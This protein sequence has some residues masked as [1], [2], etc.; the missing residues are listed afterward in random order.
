MATINHYQKTAWE[1]VIEG[2]L[3]KNPAAVAL[4]R[5]GGRKGGKARAAKMTPEERSKAA[6]K[7]ARARWK[8][9]RSR[10]VQ[11]ESDKRGGR[12]FLGTGAL[13]RFRV[14]VYLDDRFGTSQLDDLEL[15]ARRKGLSNQKILEYRQLGWWPGKAYR[16]ALRESVRKY[17]LAEVATFEEDGDL[18]ADPAPG[19]SASDEDVEYLLNDPAFVAM[20]NEIRNAIAEGTSGAPQ[21]HPGTGASHRGR[22]RVVATL[23]N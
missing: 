11:L 16:F 19:E 10:T 14:R 8:K 1:V 6:R 13:R 4:G 15:W 12:W 20:V 23:G 9:Y 21:R 7:A 2:S 18:Q 3:Q 22:G 17:A 5:L